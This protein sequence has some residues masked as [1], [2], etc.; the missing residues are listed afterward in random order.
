MH[1]TFQAGAFLHVH[2]CDKHIHFLLPFPVLFFS[3]LKA[4]SQ[5]F[6]FVVGNNRERGEIEAVKKNLLLLKTQ[7]FFSN[8]LFS[9]LKT[10]S[11][12]I[13]EIFL[14]NKPVSNNIYNE[15]VEPNPSLLYC[16]H[17][18]HKSTGLR[19]W[20]VMDRFLTSGGQ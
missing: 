10:N 19:L 16:N 7:A 17:L 11:I 12:K 9:V 13:F 5:T 18:K 20:D 15:V 1:K 4:K 2:F 14:K 8:T 6:I 3:F